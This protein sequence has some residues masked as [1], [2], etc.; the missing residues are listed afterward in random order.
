MLRIQALCGW[1]LG[2]SLVKMILLLE[3]NHYENAGEDL[4]A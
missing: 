4:T 2:L 1:R 3:V